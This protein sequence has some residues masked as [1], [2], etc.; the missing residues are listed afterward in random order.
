[1]NT[2]AT[3]PPISF[4]MKIWIQQSTTNQTHMELAHGS[5]ATNKLCTSDFLKKKKP[6]H[7]P[8][9]HSPHNNVVRSSI[10]LVW[11]LEHVTAVCSLSRRNLQAKIKHWPP[12]EAV[13]AWLTL[14]IRVFFEKG[15]KKKKKKKLLFSGR[16][17]S[18]FR[19]LYV[20]AQIWAPFKRLQTIVWT[21]HSFI[22]IPTP[23]P[24]SIQL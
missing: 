7:F 4:Q 6:P 13:W 15:K 2:L 10:E 12:E 14:Q 11:P 8:K 20:L 3:T 5:L 24:S 23:P 9:P 17:L 22:S 19:Q 16:D 18:P 1:M 21:G